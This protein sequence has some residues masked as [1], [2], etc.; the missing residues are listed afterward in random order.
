[1]GM[2]PSNVVDNGGPSL[3]LRQK[4]LDPEARMLHLHLALGDLA[5]ENFLPVDTSTEDPLSRH[6]V[7]QAF[8]LAVTLPSFEGRSHLVLAQEI[9]GTNQPVDQLVDNNQLGDNNQRSMEE[10]DDV[11]PHVPI[12]NLFVKE[13]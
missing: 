10:I 2:I 7:L 1:M 5:I 4:Q 3:S 12:F 13:L 9:L 6:Q 11:K 8:E